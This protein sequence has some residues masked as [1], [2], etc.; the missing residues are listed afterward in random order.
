MLVQHRSQIE[1]ILLSISFSWMNG[2]PQLVWLIKGASFIQKTAKIFKQ[3]LNIRITEFG[4]FNV[5]CH[6]NRNY[7]KNRSINTHRSWTNG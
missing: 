4:R 6:E 7:F 1:R 3:C 2:L 5:T